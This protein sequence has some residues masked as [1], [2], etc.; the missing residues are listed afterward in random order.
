MIGRASAT[1]HSGDVND[2]SIDDL[3]SRVANAPDDGEAAFDYASALDAAGREAD[4]IPIYR[5]ALSCDLLEQTRYRTTVQLGSSLRVVGDTHEAVAVH[6]DAVRRWPQ[7][8]ANRLF[9]ALALL[10]AGRAAEAV[11]HALTV[12]LSGDTDSDIS[13][14]RRALTAYADQLAGGQ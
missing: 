10:E 3:A 4:A 2:D 5:R 11:S 8:T 13:Y 14:Y 6:Q 9:L 12:S 1:G 7:G